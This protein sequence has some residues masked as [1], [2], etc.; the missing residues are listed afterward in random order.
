MSNESHAT[1]GV[2]PWRNFVL[3]FGGLY[4]VMAAVM[5]LTGAAPAA[6]LGTPAAVLLG[7]AIGM[8]IV[9]HRKTRN[10]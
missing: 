3:A 9:R 4:A 10:P 5:L 6:A 8:G 2:H 7:P 1:H